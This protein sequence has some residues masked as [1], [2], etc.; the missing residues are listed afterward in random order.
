MSARIRGF[1]LVELIVVM[2][3]T[4]VLA[5]IL[6]V[7]FRPAINS[8]VSV[9]NRAELTDVADSAMRTMLRDI[10]LAVPNSFRSPNNS[11]FEMIPT[12][13]GGRYRNAAD[14]VS[15]GSAP[16]DTSAPTLAFDVVTPLFTQ[17]AVGDWVVVNNQNTNDAYTGANRAQIAAAGPPPPPAAPAPPNPALGQLRITLAAPGMTF[18]AGHDSARFVIVPGA[19]GPVFY[20]C[21]DVGLDTKGNGKGIL[22]RFSNYGFNPALPG[23]CPTPTATTPVVATGISQCILTFDPNPGAIQGAGY[24][25]IKLQLTVN[26]ESVE[27]LSGAHTDNLP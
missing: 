27:L 7:F 15:P 26:N 5:G 16:V 13:A 1:T 10:R 23:T 21:H 14:T 17:P 24:V 19:Q 9:V 11:C 25:E 20:S 2:V 4:G 18:P 12:S 3:I 22:Y 8:Y 6:V